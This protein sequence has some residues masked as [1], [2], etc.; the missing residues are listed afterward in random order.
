MQVKQLDETIFCAVWRK[1][2]K[3]LMFASIGIG[4]MMI[5]LTP[6]R[7]ITDL[8]GVDVP[9]ECP[10]G[11]TCNPPPPGDDG[12]GGGGGNPDL[13]P[14]V[15]G[16]HPPG[17]DNSTQVPGEADANCNSGPAE[18]AAGNLFR[19]WQISQHPTTW[20]FVAPDGNMYKIKFADGK[21]ATFRWGLSLFESLPLQPASGCTNS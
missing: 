16:G 15:G 4:V 12:S 9:G 2:R 18:L 11:W 14:P 21:Y 20:R 6:A 8:P 19:E 7:A 1:S 3:T 17:N 5:P 10:A 13:D